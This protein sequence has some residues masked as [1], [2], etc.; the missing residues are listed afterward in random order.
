MPAVIA[1]FR[2]AANHKQAAF[3][4]HVFTQVL[5]D[6]GGFVESPANFDRLFLGALLVHTARKAGP[7][8]GIRRTYN[9]FD[10][11]L[12]ANLLAQCYRQAFLFGITPIA[13]SYRIP[14]TFA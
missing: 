10:V 13:R 3:D 4:A 14:V 1:T 6:L 2:P 11:R 5:S 7:Q 9:Q 12:T 8:F